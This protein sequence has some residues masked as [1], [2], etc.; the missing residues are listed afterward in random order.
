MYH[1]GRTPPK[2]AV[3]HEDEVRLLCA[4]ALENKPVETQLYHDLFL[5]SHLDEQSQVLS[6]GCRKRQLQYSAVNYTLIMPHCID[7]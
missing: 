7:Y 4:V 2:V 3:P 5:F 1:I 6:D